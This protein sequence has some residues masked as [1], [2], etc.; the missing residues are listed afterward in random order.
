[1]EDRSGY[2]R[3]ARGEALRRVRGRRRSQQVAILP[4]RGAARSASAPYHSGKRQECR[5]TV[6]QAR[7]PPGARGGQKRPLPRGAARWRARAGS[8]ALFCGVWEDV[9]RKTQ[10]FGCFGGAR[11]AS[12]SLTSYVLRPLLNLPVARRALNVVYCAQWRIV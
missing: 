9:G 8:P 7:D 3:G 1:M 6:A 4:A 10:D 5:F 12:Q 2:K 11:K